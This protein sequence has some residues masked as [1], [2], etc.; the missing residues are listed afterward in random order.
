[1]F[2]TDRED[3]PLRD[4]NG[5]PYI[6]LVCI[7]ETGNQ[8]YHSLFFSETGRAKVNAFVFAVGLADQNSGELNLKAEDFV[9]KKF[10]GKVQP[11]TYNGKTYNSIFRVERLGENIAQEE[12][13]QE[14]KEDPD[15]EEDILF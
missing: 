3:Q 12:P 11:K 13:K 6:Q 8:V 9:G 2:E 7:A 1:M 10:R 15:L 14:S 5:N 4:K